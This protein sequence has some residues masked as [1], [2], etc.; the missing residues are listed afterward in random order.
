VRCIRRPH[1][2]RLGTV[3]AMPDPP[4]VLATG[5]K[6]RVLAVRLDGGGEAVV[7]R[8]NVEIIADE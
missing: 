4:Q 3:A 1:F 5:S 7:P 6:V 2:G 8:A